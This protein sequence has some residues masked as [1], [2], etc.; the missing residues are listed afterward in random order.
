M[1]KRVRKHGVD[2]NRSCNEGVM[3]KRVSV[4]EPWT[5]QLQTAVSPNT[6]RCFRRYRSQTNHLTSLYQFCP[7]SASIR[8]CSSRKQP[9]NRPVPTVFLSIFGSS[10]SLNSSPNLTSKASEAKLN[11]RR[12]LQEVQ[13]A[14][15]S[16]SRVCRN[17]P[18]GLLLAP[19]L[20]PSCRISCNLLKFL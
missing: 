4:A 13:L 1:A 17:P 2:P 18:P 5:S 16:S 14:R 19:T 8:Y 7:T 6:G 10:F 9:R 15:T 3:V 12:D 11:H 20:F